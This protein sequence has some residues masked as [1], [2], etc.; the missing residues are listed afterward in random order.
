[1]CIIHTALMCFN[2]NVIPLLNAIAQVESGNGKFS[3]NIYQISDIYIDDVNRI[4]GRKEFTY[5]DK[6]DVEKSVEMMVIYWGR[7]GSIYESKTGNAVSYSVL[8]RIHNG[9]PDGWKKY[10]TKRYAKRVMNLMEEKK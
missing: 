2:L 3:K 7:Y 5:D 9:G 10:A 1:M 6:Y 8:A 4:L